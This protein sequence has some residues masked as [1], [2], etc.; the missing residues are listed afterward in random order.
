MTSLR[1]I[2]ADMMRGC[3]EG[4]LGVGAGE[5]AGGGGGWTEVVMG[6]GVVEVVEAGCGGR[7]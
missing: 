3:Y 2:S 6:K 4:E 7:A 5:W 1:R